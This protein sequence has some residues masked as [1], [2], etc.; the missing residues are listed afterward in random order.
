MGAANKR[1]PGSAA[2][3]VIIMDALSMALPVLTDRQQRTHFNDD[4]K[5]INDDS[6]S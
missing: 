2:Q 5:Q 3:P 1:K 6:L 4:F